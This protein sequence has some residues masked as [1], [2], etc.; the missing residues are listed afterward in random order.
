M[1][2]AG[3]NAL[4]QDPRVLDIV[5][6]KDMSHGVSCMIVVVVES[7]PYRSRGKRSKH[8]SSKGDTGH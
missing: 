2:L 5:E 3:K 1:S 6:Y 7:D 8:S 4:N